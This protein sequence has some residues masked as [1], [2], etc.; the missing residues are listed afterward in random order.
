M[1]SY[2]T[3]IEKLLSTMKWEYK[4][5]R[6]TYCA[7]TMS[8]V[9]Y[10][11][12]ERGF[13]NSGTSEL[14]YFC[15]KGS[16]PKCFP[17]ARAHVDIGSSAYLDTMAKVL[18]AGLGELTYVS[19]VDHAKAMLFMGI[20]SQKAEEG[21]ADDNDRSDDEGKKRKYPKRNKGRSFTE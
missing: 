3:T 6:L 11:M 1:K 16:M 5:I 9:G 13:A 12:R 19:S 17:N 21:V 20:D 4:E 14:M 10:W 15:W 18:V 2:E 7:K 8:E